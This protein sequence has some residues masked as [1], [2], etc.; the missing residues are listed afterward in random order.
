MCLAGAGAGAAAAALPNEV[1][2]PIART[3]FRILDK[4]DTTILPF[5]LSNMTARCGEI[6]TF[7]FK[8]RMWSGNGVFISDRHA[9]VQPCGLGM[10]R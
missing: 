8:V 6:R 10:E 5:G 3:S 9:I 1:K 7:N 4:F 2:Q